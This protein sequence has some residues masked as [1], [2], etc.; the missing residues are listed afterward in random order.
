MQITDIGNVFKCFHL[1]LIKKECAN[2]I[3]TEQLDHIIFFNIS[4]I[5]YSLDIL[6]RYNWHSM[7]SIQILV[8]L[9]QYANKY[10]ELLFNIYNDHTHHIILS[11]NVQS[12]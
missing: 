4:D 3:H 9:V 2:I 7:V 8:R 1:Q 11:V 6:C 10:Q 5:F 12:R